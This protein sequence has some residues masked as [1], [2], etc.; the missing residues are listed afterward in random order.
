LINLY[1]S[2]R[3]NEDIELKI[4]GDADERQCLMPLLYID[5]DE[6]T[7]ESIYADMTRLLKE[8]HL[9]EDDSRILLPSNRMK[10]LDIVKVL[11]GINS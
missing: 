6:K 8:F 11:M 9:G 5:G 2:A 4:A 7:R 10:P 3:R 1:F